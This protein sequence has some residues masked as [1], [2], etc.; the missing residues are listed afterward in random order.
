V[1]ALA[2]S[3][4]DHAASVERANWLVHRALLIQI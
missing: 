1:P 2:F 4:S 3:G